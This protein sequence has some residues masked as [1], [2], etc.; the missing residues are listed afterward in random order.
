MKLQTI[1]TIAAVFLLVGSVQGASATTFT[2]NDSACCGSG[3]F[4]TVAVTQVGPVSNGVVDVLVTLNPGVDFVNTGSAA[5]GN[6]PDL[7]FQLAG[8]DSI[9]GV[10]IVQDGAGGAWTWDFYDVHSTLNQVSMSDSFGKYEYALYC[11]N[12]GSGASNGNP[13]PLEF[14]ITLPGL[15]PASFIAN[16]A[17][18]IFAADVFVPSGTTGNTG[19]VRATGPDTPPPSVPEP[20]TLLLLGTG[21]FGTATAARRRKKQ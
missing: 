16:S 21:L 12:C 11:S 13:G 9:G 3:P 17:G 4:G 18:T 7:A 10:A 5:P 14:R 1:G 15:T 2:L 19:L 6:H 8:D 20:T